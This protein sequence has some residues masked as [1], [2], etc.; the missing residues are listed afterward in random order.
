MAGHV[1]R[2]PRPRPSLHGLRDALADARAAGVAFDEAWT[3]ARDF[4]EPDVRD[5]TAECWRRAYCGEPATAREEAVVRL[6]A[7]FERAGVDAP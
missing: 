5:D 6:A 2:P 7:L 3:V 4:L 1:G